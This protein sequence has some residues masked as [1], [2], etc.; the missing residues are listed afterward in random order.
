VPYYAQ[1][2]DLHELPGCEL[3]LYGD[4]NEVRGLALRHIRDADAAIVTSYCPDGVQASRLVLDSAAGLRIFYDL[5]TP[6]TLARIANGESVE[7]LGPAGLRDFDLVLSFTGGRSLDEL[8][9]VLG[10]RRTAPLYGSADPELHAP[11]RRDPRYGGCLGYLGTY[12]AD[13]AEGV[14]RF[15]GEPARC[16]PD[17]RFVLAGPRYGEDFPWQPNIFYMSHLIPQE[18]AAFYCSTRLTL[19]VTR[20]AMAESGYCP[21]GRLFEATACGAAVLSDWWEGLDRF[22]KPGAEILIAHETEDVLNALD[23]SAEE[24]AR[25]AQAGRERTLAEHSATARAMDFENILQG[26]F[27][28][29]AGAA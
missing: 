8:K 15:F 29:S 24:L 21:S 10:A 7:Y 26:V 19:N 13:R 12:A 22:F 2:R 28:S 5:D 17:G 18:H 23:R 16:R 14:R 1:H 11:A 20:R 3:I 25:I 4:W 27:A 6:V 9:R